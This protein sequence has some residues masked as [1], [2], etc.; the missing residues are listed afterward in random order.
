MRLALEQA[1]LFLTILA[2]LEFF[3]FQTFSDRQE[4]WHRRSNGQLYDPLARVYH[5]TLQQNE[6]KLIR[7]NEQGAG[8]FV[9]V[10]AGDGNGRAAKNVARV[11][12]L[13]VDC[14]GAPLPLSTPLEPHLKVQSSPGRW[15]LYWLVY[16]LRLDD[17]APMQGALAELY[18]TDPAVVDLPRV[19]RLPGFH[20]LKGDPVTVQLVE[21]KTHAPYV[22]SELLEAWPCLAGVLER[23]A[24]AER[25]RREIQERT[26]HMPLTR[27]VGEHAK[28][29]AILRGHC[30][31]V[32]RAGEGTRHNT[33]GYV[34]GGY[35][36]PHRV[37]SA[38]LGAAKACGLPGDEAAS[39]V[40]WGLKKGAQ[41]PLELDG[42]TSV[43]QTTFVGPEKPLSYRA[44]IAA[45]MKR[46]GR[47][48]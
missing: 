27:D 12:A 43:P 31:T 13:F 36:E 20:H 16:G 25:E 17:F 34:G 7:A 1:L 26:K 21:A 6:R 15:H 48:A 38:L 32:A 2:R 10:N 44:R 46:W 40:H 37:A 4:T 28:A 22:R 19:M 18:G 14:D 5:G 24:K 11:R 35:L 29:H 23:R 33:L 8:V 45:R 3:T 42:A 9:M 39:V 47:G 30:E 41:N